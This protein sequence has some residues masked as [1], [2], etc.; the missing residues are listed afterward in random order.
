[1]NSLGGIHHD[2]QLIEGRK[3]PK[4]HSL[5]LKGHYVYWP[6]PFELYD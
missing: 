1:M 6:D 4:A 5:Y 2:E 3:V